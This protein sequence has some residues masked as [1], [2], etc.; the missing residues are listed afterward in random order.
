MSLPRPSGLKAPSKIGKPTGL[1]QPK[2]SIPATE[3]AKSK[4]YACFLNGFCV[5]LLCVM[6]LC[7]D[8]DMFLC[9]CSVSNFIK[10]FFYGMYLRNVV[11][12]N[13]YLIVSVFVLKFYCYL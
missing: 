12:I 1:P 4:T 2:S 6:C 11:T 3:K 8:I 5:C 7:I 9:T 10:P 13:F